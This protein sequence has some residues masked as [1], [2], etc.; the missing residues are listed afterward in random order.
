MLEV[1][2]WDADSLPQFLSPLE[3]T[4]D[5]WHV[6]V[7]WN[8][9]IVELGAHL[10]V[11]DLLGNVHLFVHHLYKDWIF[12]LKVLLDQWTVQQ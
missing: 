9:A 1:G 8:L 11:I 7:D 4:A 2:H 3:P 6:L 10:K 5:I 12:L